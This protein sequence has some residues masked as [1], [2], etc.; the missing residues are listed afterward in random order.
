MYGENEYKLYNINIFR[1]KYVIN[2]FTENALH[3][4]YY[5]DVYRGPKLS[6]HRTDK[7]TYTFNEVRQARG[8]R[9]S[10]DCAPIALKCS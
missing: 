10:C 9:H 3:M 1:L 5:L 2:C 8:E 4:I 6:Y 7:K